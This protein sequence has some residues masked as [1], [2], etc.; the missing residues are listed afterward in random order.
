MTKYLAVAIALISLAACGKTVDPND[1]HNDPRYC[2]VIGHSATDSV[3]PADKMWFEQ[4]CICA[5]TDKLDMDAYIRS[6]LKSTPEYV[7]VC[8]HK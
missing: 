4:N 3:P 8:K 2:D 6:G 7:V 1:P 5:D